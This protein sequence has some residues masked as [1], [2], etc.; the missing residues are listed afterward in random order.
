MNF[1]AL[2]NRYKRECGVSGPAI[3]NVDT[4]SN[5]HLRLRDWIVSAWVDIQSMHNGQWQFMR[6]ESSY[7]T[8]AWMTL[9]SIPEW[10]ADSVN[11]WKID[12]FRI[13]AL[14][15]SR[16]Q[17][18]PIDY[19]PYDQF[20]ASVGLNPSEQNRPRY[21]TVRPGDKAVILAPACDAAYTLYFE[22]FSEPVELEDNNDVPACPSKYHMLIVYEA[23]LSYGAFEAAAEVLGRAEKKKRELLFNMQMTQLPPITFG[24]PLA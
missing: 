16:A 3:T 7:N 17:S 21:F 24:G 4:V 5:E 9:L 18:W 13:S 10:A 6:E 15:E 8:S 23:M 19:I 14:G 20:V 2:I 12:T 22:Y 1:L 11:I